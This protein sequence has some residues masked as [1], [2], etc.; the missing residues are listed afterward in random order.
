MTPE[1]KN[2][3]EENRV[4]NQKLAERLAARKA[5]ANEQEPVSRIQQNYREDADR[6]NPNPA[7]TV[8]DSRGRPKEKSNHHQWAG[9]P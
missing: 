1:Q 7:A 9:Q 5:P 6:Q 8:L 4:S 3:M 2:R